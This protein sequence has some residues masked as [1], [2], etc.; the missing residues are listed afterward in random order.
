MFILVPAVSGAYVI[1]P[2]KVPKEFWWWSKSSLVYH[3]ALLISYGVVLAEGGF[4][5]DV[6][7]NFADYW[8]VNL[9]SSIAVSDSGGFEIHSRGVKI[10]LDDLFEWQFSNSNIIFSLDIPPRGMSKVDDVRDWD[11][12]KKIS[13]KN[14]E[15]LLRYS[16]S[17]KVENRK[18]YGVVHGIALEELDDWYNYVLKDYIYS[19][20]GLSYSVRP[21]SNVNALSLCLAHAYVH[22]VKNVHMLGVT[23]SRTIPFM[24]YWKNKFRLLTTDSSSFTKLA[25]RGQVYMPIS[26]DRVQVGARLSAYHDSVCHCPACQWARKKG[27]MNLFKLNST[28]KYV[29]AYMHNLF[30]L[31]C[32]VD[33]LEWLPKEKIKDLLPQFQETFDF[34]DCVEGKSLE[35]C[36][37]MFDVLSDVK[38]RNVLKKPRKRWW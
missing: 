22:D 31:L 8:K 10:D 20:D 9:D 26:L 23:G 28:L 37:S 5:E 13:R 6:F 33:Y 38:S 21:P 7:R 15:E 17:R 19:L 29:V 2:D 34:L 36:Y 25:G 12:C 27:I 1:T 30:W 35:E 24:I 11:Y 32:Y 4:N 14:L 3:P 18:I 16:S